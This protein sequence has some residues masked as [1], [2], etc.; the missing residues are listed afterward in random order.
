M[1][2]SSEG[3]GFFFPRVDLADMTEDR[4]QCEMIGVV[5]DVVRCALENLESEPLPAKSDSRDQ[6]TENLFIRG[7]AS[8][9]IVVCRC[10]F[11]FC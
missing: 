5:I 10:A 11:F 7:L 4:L 1:T 2:L 6:K 8:N 3:V 9:S